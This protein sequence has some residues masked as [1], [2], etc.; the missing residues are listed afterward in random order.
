MDQEYL[1]QEFT[2][3]AG[4]PI[5]MIKD[6]KI[7]QNPRICSGAYAVAEA[8]YASLNEETP[9]LWITMAPEDFSIGGMCLS[10]LDC[11]LLV[12]PVFAYECSNAQARRILSRLG[13]SSDET[14]G[15]QRDLNRLR[16]YDINE[17]RQVLVFLH[18]WLDGSEAEVQNVS[19]HW[20]K[21]YTGSRAILAET[22]P[23]GFSEDIENKIVTM[24]R[25]GKTDALRK[26]FNETLF[27]RDSTEANR[28]MNTKQ[29]RRYMIG[30]NMYMSRVAAAEGVDL[31]LISEMVD[32]Y[33]ERI[34]NT[35]AL[36]DFNHLFLEFSIRYTRMVA[37]LISFSSHSMLASQVNRYVQAH[38]YENIRLEDIARALKYSKTYVSAEFKKTSGETVTDFILK[39]KIREASYLLEQ[40]ALPVFE[41]GEALGFYDASYF[42]RVF[43]RMTG[44]TPGRFAERYKGLRALSG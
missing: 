12:A 26:F 1:I 29:M 23:P 6:G 36:S 8:V 22:P 4:L 30:A 25:Y 19:F 14:F 42:I 44:L 39:C 10:A 16:R 38:L 5:V 21:A 28:S 37:D 7:I 43:K 13:L 15:F 9:A 2:E 35:T 33:G 31:A 20:E 11:Q 3:A 17:L 24:I 18:D 32:R 27:S 41:I 40:N 34:E